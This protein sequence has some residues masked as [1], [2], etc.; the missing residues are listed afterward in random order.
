MSDQIAKVVVG[1]PVEGPFDY[2]IP[3]GL[4]VR[5]G[6]RVWVSFLNSRRVGYVVG[7]CSKSRFARLKNILAVLDNEPVLSPAVLEQTRRFAQYYGCSWGEA[8]ETALPVS[9]RRKT[10]EKFEIR[11]SMPKNLSEQGQTLLCHDPDGQGAWPY[12]VH[13][14][15]EKLDQGLGVIVLVPEASL[16]KKAKTELARNIDAKMI[17]CLDK[18]LTSKKELAEWLKIKNGECRVALGTRSAVFAP[19][20]NLG[21]IVVSDEDNSSYKQDQSPFY[22]VRHVANI[23]QDL[24]KA[25]ILYSA[26]VPTAELMFAVQKKK[27]QIHVCADEKL[28]KVQLI[29]MTNYKPQMN[30]PVSFPL[31]NQMERLLAEQKRSLLLINR[32]GFS[33]VTRCNKCGMIVRCERCKVSMAY[34][35]SKKMLVCHRCDQEQPLPERCPQ[36]SSPYLRSFGTGVEKIAS[37]LARIFPQANIRTFDR[38]TKG[39][40]SKADI[41]VATSAVLRIVD[42][43]DV[44]MAA[45]LDL[46]AQLNRADFRSAQRAFSLLVKLRQCANEQVVVQTL[47]RDT[48]CLKAASTM[49]FKAFYRQEL[50]F[51]KDAGFPPF[52]HLV[53]VVLRGP[54][55]QMVFEKAKALHERLC[56][57]VTKA[58]VMDPQPDIT[59]KLRG[60]YRMSIMLKSRSVVPLL[61]GVRQALKGFRKKKDLIVTVNI[62]P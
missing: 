23:R 21:L 31:R 32:R 12:I 57:N 34:L 54:D 52:G 2:R 29:D 40:P 10:R 28:A 20:P 6:G 15:K 50:G 53:S 62:D 46:D 8:I 33:D 51:R 60:K 47:S 16:F 58:E 36:C 9:L 43:L 27:A 44:D 39:V 42:E 3:E 24:E 7:L 25:D 17:A 45:V 14:V 41:I 11:G 1:L 49:D 38:E 48:Y 22:Y 18:R 5:E 56:A 35:F 30:L 19:V 55:E 37:E 13:R 26:S 4:S 61:K 59:P